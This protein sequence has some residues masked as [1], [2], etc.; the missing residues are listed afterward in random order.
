MKPTDDGLDLENSAYKGA[1][2]SGGKGSGLITRRMSG[3]SVYVVASQPGVLKITCEKGRGSYEIVLRFIG[4][5]EAF[6]VYRE[7]KYNGSET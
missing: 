7:E 3:E 6:R 4:D 2:D 1:V 5:R